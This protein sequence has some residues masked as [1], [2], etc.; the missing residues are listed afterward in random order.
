[1]NANPNKEMASYFGL[2]VEV[3]C[4][5]PHCALIRYGDR[6]FVVDV[7]DLVCVQRNRRAA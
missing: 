1:M 7:S 6:E 5:M 3:I 2:T 4:R